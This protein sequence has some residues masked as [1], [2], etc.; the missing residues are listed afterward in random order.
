MMK[1]TFF[2]SLDYISRNDPHTHRFFKSFKRNGFYFNEFGYL[3]TLFLIILNH[4]TGVAK[5][6]RKGDESESDL[7]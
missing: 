7:S 1:F 6:G 2:T 3:V 5:R 4:Q